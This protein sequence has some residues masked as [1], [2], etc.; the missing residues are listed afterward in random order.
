MWRELKSLAGWDQ[1]ETLPRR[2]LDEEDEEVE[3]TEALKIWA[4]SFEKLGKENF[5]DPKFDREDSERIMDAVRELEEREKREVEAEVPPGE[6]LDLLNLP[7]TSDD[8][9]F[10]FLELQTGKAAGVDGVV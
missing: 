5:E 7:I 2:I 10:A 3:G 1:K 8:G 4:S 6:A 9:L